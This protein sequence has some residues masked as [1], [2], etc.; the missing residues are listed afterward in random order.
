MNRAPGTPT[1]DLPQDRPDIA[2]CAS[3]DVSERG[4]GLRFPVRVGGSDATGFLIR[5]HGAVHAYLNRCAHVPTEMDGLPGDF[6][7]SGRELLMC[8]IHGAM[9][10]PDSGR[11]IVGPCNGARLY[12]LCAVEKDGRIFWTPDDYVRPAIA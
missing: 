6:F 7:N 10:M 3:G 2:L 9:Y 8:A 11:C 1:P 12:K 5:Y 4:K